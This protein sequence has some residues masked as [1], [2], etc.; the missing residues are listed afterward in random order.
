MK[1][2]IEWIDASTAPSDWYK[3]V[4]YVTKSR[5]MGVFKDTV[6]WTGGDPKKNGVTPFFLGL[7]KRKI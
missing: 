5:K 2:T 6:S 7:V 4:A 3:P 1:R